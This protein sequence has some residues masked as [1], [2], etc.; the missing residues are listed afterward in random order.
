MVTVLSLAQAL[1]FTVGPTAALLKGQDR[2]GTYLR[3]QAWQAV[4]IVPALVLAA[5]LGSRWVG[6]ENGAALLVATATLV[7]Y[8][9]F[10]PAGVWLGIRVGGGS[11]RDA[12]SAFAPS[13]V[14]SLAIGV[15]AWFLVRGV[16]PTGLVGGGRVALVA[17]AS[18]PIYALLLRAVDR[19]TF[20][21]LSGS[22]HKILVRLRL[23]S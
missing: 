6:L 18:F 1:A 14:A 22:M 2:F 12:L 5:W 8:A 3:W 10:S 20:H 15:P 21:E 19:E 9:L 11:L 16:D 7:T 4:F 23:R 13:L 17:V